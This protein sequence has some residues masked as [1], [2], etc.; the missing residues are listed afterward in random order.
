[1]PRKQLA[2]ELRRLRT[3]AGATLEG[4]AMEL[5]ISTSKLS[6]LENGQG[7]P[8]AR[9]VRDL[10]RHYQI[11]NTPEAEQLMRWVRAAGKRAWWDDYAGTVLAGLDVHLA[12]ESEA[13]LIRVYTIPVLPVLLQTAD[14]TRTLLQRMEPWRSPSELDELLQVRERRRQ[15]LESREEMPPLRLIAVTHEASIRQMVGTAEIMRAQLDHLVERSEMPNVDFRILPLSATPP[16][17]CTCMYA[18]FE[19][20]DYDRDVVNI[21]THAGFRYIETTELVVRYRRYYDELVRSSLSAED[22]RNLVRSIKEDSFT[23]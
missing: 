14:Y 13:S 22:T 21:E 7:R 6:R 18:Y 2:A 12:T 17:T 15:A 20:D 4:V 3:A 10:I 11:E 5:M 23:D 1:M 19:F 16:F 9:D 8:Q